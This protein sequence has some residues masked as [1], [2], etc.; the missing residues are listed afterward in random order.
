MSLDLDKLEALTSAATAPGRPLRAEPDGFGT[1]EL[2]DAD[3][4]D[5]PLASDV[6]AYAAEAFVALINAAPALIAAARELGPLRA[7]VERLSADLDT[8]HAGRTEA[9]AL[10]AGLELQVED[11]R[12]L[13]REAAA[14]VSGL[15]VDMPR[16]CGERA[17]GIVRRLREAGGG[18]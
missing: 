9:R 18:A 17:D 16:E 15:D 1:F 10:V 7:I 11:L 8:M 13:C 14:V 4:L 3:P 6:N 12:A 2:L 5:P